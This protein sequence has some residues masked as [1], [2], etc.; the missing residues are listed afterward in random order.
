MDNK[1]QRSNVFTGNIYSGLAQAVAPKHPSCAE[2][3]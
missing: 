3:N 2:L 1:G